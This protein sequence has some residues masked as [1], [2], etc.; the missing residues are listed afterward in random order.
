MTERLAGGRLGTV[1]EG[2]IRDCFVFPGTEY[3]AGIEVDGQHARKISYGINPLNDRVYIYDLTIEGD[4]RRCGLATATLW[5][6][7]CTH[8]VP[9]VPLHEVG[10]AGTRRASG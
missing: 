5:R 3:D 6:L 7:W 8:Q 2:D 1:R 9:L 10:T 4:S